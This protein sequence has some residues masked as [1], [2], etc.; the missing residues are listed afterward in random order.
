M[1][2][3]QIS[4][5][6]GI[7]NL[8]CF[9]KRWTLRSSETQPLKQVHPYPRERTR[10][11]ASLVIPAAILF[12]LF[13]LFFFSPSISWAIFGQNTFA[14]EIL[15]NV[16]QFLSFQMHQKIAIISYPSQPSSLGILFCVYFIQRES[17]DGIHPLIPF[18]TFISPLKG[19]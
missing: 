16:C 17:I 10:V 15:R 3:S 7:Q 1:Q 5:S 18:F 11:F 19:S 4:S 14:H 8:K 9:Y 2:L 12:L 13:F 6:Y